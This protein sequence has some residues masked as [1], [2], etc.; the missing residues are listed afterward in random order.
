MRNLQ[1]LVKTSRPHFWIY[2]AGTFLLG[3]IIAAVSVSELTTS[4]VM[5]WGFYFLI[6]ANLLIYGVNDVFDYE[7]DIKN[8]KKIT[9]ESVLPK[10]K[11]R[12]VLLTVLLTT[13]PFV[14][15]TTQFSISQYTAVVLFWFCAL[16]YSMPPI[17]AKARAFVDGLFS[18][19]HYVATGVF[20]YFLLQP[21]AATPWIAI[22]GAMAWAMAMHA[23]SAVPDIEADRAA[24]LETTATV[25]GAKRTLWYCTALYTIAMLAGH[26]LFGWLS[27]MLFVP[28]LCLMFISYRKEGPAL[29]SVYAYFPYLNAFTGMVL[30][31]I[32]FYSNGWL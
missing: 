15:F 19:G 14:Y 32:A 16:C 23:Y 5:L 9:Y 13:M 29:L 11:H 7:T 10:E 25:L 18:A 17:R 21:E 24:K 30:C 1:L 2:E 3:A 26:V 20:G 31:F 12:L 22:G 8:P 27:L 4:M 6:P 28:Y